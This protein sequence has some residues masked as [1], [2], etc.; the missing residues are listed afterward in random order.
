MCSPVTVRAQVFEVTDGRSL[1]ITLLSRAERAR[2]GLIKARGRAGLIKA[3]ALRWRTT[4]IR[5]RRAPEQ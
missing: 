1:A 2:A 4:F 3:R 5:C